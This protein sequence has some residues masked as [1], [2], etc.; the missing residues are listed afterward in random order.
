L[1]RKNTLKI[2]IALL[3]PLVLLV[4]PTYSQE[5]RELRARKKRPHFTNSGIQYDVEAEEKMMEDYKIVEVEQNRILLA[6]K[7]DSKDKRKPTAFVLPHKGKEELVQLPDRES[8]L[9]FKTF[10]DFASEEDIE[11]QQ[12]QRENTWWGRLYVEGLPN[13]FQYFRG[14]YGMTPPSGNYDLVL[15]EPIHMCDF[16]ES[17]GMMNNADKVTPSTFIVA[18]RGNCTFGGECE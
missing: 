14:H 17:K 7:D 10:N 18:R 4:L 13:N 6:P 5:F 9:K 12:E 3:V 2:L 1:L 8:V 15:A 11:G 16:V